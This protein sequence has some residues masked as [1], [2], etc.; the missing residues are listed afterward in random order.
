M[1]QETKKDSS[2]TDSIIL[3]RLAIKFDLEINDDVIN[4]Y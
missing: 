4:P 2:L 3:N 1:N